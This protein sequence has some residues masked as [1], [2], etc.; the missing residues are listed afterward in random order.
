MF[1]APLHAHRKE[2]AGVG[3]CKVIQCIHN[4][5]LECQASSIDVGFAN[6]LADC[7]TYELK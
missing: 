2:R 6:G 7:M 1:T 4:E 5:D 3:A